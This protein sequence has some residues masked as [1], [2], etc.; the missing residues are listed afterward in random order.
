MA[1]LIGARAKV[2]KDGSVAVVLY[3]KVE[4]ELQKF[5]LDNDGVW[6]RVGEAE[7]YPKLKLVFHQYRDDIEDLV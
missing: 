1:E 7:I 2:Y 6:Q 4:G 3:K 5:Y